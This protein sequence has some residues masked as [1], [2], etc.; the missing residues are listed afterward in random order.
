[1]SNYMFIRNGT[2]WTG[3]AGE[4]AAKR[5]MLING[6][7][8]EKVCE[9][10]STKIPHF[11]Q[12]IDATGKTV[13]PGLI[14]C[15]T[16]ITLDGRN[17]DPVTTALN[18]E[19][20]MV[21]IKAVRCAKEMLQVGV[22]TA[23]DLGGIEGVDFAI[24]KAINQGLIEGPRMLV[25][26]R[27][28][29]MTG[30]AGNFMGMEVD[31][32]DAARHAARL[33]LKAGADVIKLMATGSV[34]TEGVE[35][36]SPE[37]TLDELRAA[38]E[39]VRKRGKRTACHAQG[40]EGIKNAILAGVNTIEHGV[41]LD[42]EAIDMMVQRSVYLVPTLVAPYL[43]VERGIEA[44]VP[45]F[46]VNKAE[47]VIKDHYKS[48]RDS[49][50]AGVKIAMGNDQGAPFDDPSKIIQEM[51]LMAEN[52]L[53]PE[54]VLSSATRVGAEALGLEEQIGTLE[55]GKYADMV[56]LDGNPL[57]DLKALENVA[58]VMKE[59]QT[60]YSHKQ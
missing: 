33:Q 11:A 14:N 46:A 25:S 35:P 31:G 26:G 55:P 18:D 38:V 30:G 49:H 16:H 47:K 10:G 22:T 7:T 36:G 39:E 23:R 32:A 21:L 34:T 28:I 54:E 27:V 24:K 52:G 29:C 59:G 3:A 58:W 9:P 37:L 41:F 4:I 13:L 8:I 17:P 20:Y 40:T 51:F 12:E 5:D 2:V 56:A 1:M 48:F 43:I 44:G 45:A 53:T 6:S 50:K 57:S 42:Q 15:H 60:V 19:P